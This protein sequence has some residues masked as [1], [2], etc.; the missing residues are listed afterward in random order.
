MSE[1]IE[2]LITQIVQGKIADAEQGFNQIIS[3]KASTAI[4]QLRIE[5]IDKTFNQGQYNESFGPGALAKYAGKEKLTGDT[6]GQKMPTYGNKRDYKKIDLHAILVARAG[7]KELKYLG[8]TTWSPN[9]KTAVSK[10]EEK[11]PEHKGKIKGAYAESTEYQLDEEFFISE[12]GIGGL[13][14][15]GS[16]DV[17]KAEDSLK[18]SLAKSGIKFGKSTSTVVTKGPDGKPVTKTTTKDM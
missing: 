12:G 6:A 1:Q 5:T 17:Q 11:W 13:V 3:Q 10:A 14:K 15:F 2:T 4:E 16:P 8:S 7:M 9:V 18:S